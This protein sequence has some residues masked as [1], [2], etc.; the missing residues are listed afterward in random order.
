MDNTFTTEQIVAL[1]ARDD[2]VELALRKEIY[3]LDNDIAQ[4]T[5]RSDRSRRRRAA[6]KLNTLQETWGNLKDCLCEEDVN[7]LY[8]ISPEN[9]LR[10]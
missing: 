3:N 7:S 5:E 6:I 8:E 9:L 1:Q 2:R 4:W 10:E